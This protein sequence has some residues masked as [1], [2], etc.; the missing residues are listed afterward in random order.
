MILF[1]RNFGQKVG[2]PVKTLSLAQLLYHVGSKF[3]IFTD[4]IECAC[5][6]LYTAS[7]MT[8]THKQLKDTINLAFEFTNKHL[9][10]NVLLN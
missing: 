9:D 5:T 10:K 2:W 6:C 4:N 7:K 1:I 8:D 3:K